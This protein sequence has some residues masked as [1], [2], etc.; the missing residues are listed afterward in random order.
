[1][2]RPQF[3]KEQG[4]LANL[5]SPEELAGRLGLKTA[6]LADGRSQGKGQRISRRG[7]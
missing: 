2:D 6:T 7:E 4:I 5:L 1:M 3:D